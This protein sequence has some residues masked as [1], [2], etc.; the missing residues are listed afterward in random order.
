MDRRASRIVLL[1]MS[2]L[3]LA[4]GACAPRPHVTVPPDHAPYVLGSGD[5]VHVT[6][7]GQANL[8]ADYPID[9]AGLISL[10]LIGPVQAAGV[11]TFELQKTIASR[12]RNGY[13]RN[14]DVTVSVTSY[15]PFFVLGEVTNSGQYP[16]QAGITAEKAVAVAGG[17]SP[18]ARHDSVIIARRIRGHVVKFDAPITAPVMPGDVVTARERWF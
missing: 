1:A 2:A 8:T 3:I 17:F 14:P 15:R 9:Q 11:T 13:L 18:R 4:L 12:L 10:P 16:Y 5:K 7:Y 6:V